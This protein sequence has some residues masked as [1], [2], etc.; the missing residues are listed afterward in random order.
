MRWDQKAPSLGDCGLPSK[1]V[2]SRGRSWIAAGFRIALLMRRA[3]LRPLSPLR[4]NRS[5]RCTS[6]EVTL[7]SDFSPSL[8]TGWLS[9]QL[10]F[11]AMRCRVP[12]LEF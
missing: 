4:L 7:T 10:Q 2:V 11:T 1:E 3:Q 6:E 9:H 8:R 5:L 12:V